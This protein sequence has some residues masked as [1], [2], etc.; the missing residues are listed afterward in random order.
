MKHD[1]AL[2]QQPDKTP[3]SVHAVAAPKAHSHQGQVTPNQAS[4]RNLLSLADT[5]VHGTTT[6]SAHSASTVANSVSNKDTRKV[7]ATKILKPTRRDRPPPPNADQS[8]DPSQSVVYT[9]LLAR[10]RSMPPIAGCSSR[11][12]SMV[13]QCA[14]SWIQHPMSPSFPKSSG[15]L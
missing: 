7:F 5:V 9:A 10:S 4:R 13:L 6:N 14:C 8:Q 2:I 15:Q 1:S 3:Q 12:I 11:S